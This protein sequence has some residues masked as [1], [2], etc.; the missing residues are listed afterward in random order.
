MTV[1]FHGKSHVLTMKYVG[2]CWNIWTYDIHLGFAVVF[3]VSF[4]TVMA[5]YPIYG[6]ITPL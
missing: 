6:M 3:D 5:L 4:P 1:F 2:T